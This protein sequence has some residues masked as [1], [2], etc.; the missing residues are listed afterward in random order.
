MGRAS[1]EEPYWAY[2]KTQRPEVP[3]GSAAID[4][5]TNSKLQEK[6]R[7]S[8]DEAAQRTLARLLNFDLTGLPPS[9]QAS[10]LSPT[11]NHL[12]PA[13]SCP[14]S[15]STHLITASGWRSI[16]SVVVKFTP[17]G[18]SFSNSR[19]NCRPRAVLGAR[20]ISRSLRETGFSFLTAPPTHA[21][22]T[23]LERRASP[24]V[25]QPG[26]LRCYVETP[27]VEAIEV[28]GLDWLINLKVN[29]NQL[30]CS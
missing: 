8:V 27:F 14:I 12:A 25:E 19:W 7:Q 9:S 5:F 26:P 18:N 28:L 17:Q 6:G 29:T 3:E 24:D 13:K 20:S 2:I 30:S 10:T 15:F 1:A 11:T 23:R 22:L 4:Y 16:G 21:F